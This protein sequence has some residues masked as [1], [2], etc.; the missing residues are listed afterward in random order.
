MRYGRFRVPSSHRWYRNMRQLAEA[1][2]ATALI[3]SVTTT[4]TAMHNLGRTKATLGHSP[5]R[6]NQPTGR[7]PILLLGLS[8]GV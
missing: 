7:R 8:E 2:N 1:A 4:T 5:A 3:A 6:V